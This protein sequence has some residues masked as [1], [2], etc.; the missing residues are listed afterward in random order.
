M[1]L[2]PVLFFILMVSVSF[3]YDFAA[4]PGDGS[5]ANPYQI[6]EPNQLMSIGSDPNLLDKHFILVSDIEF[7]PNNNPAHVFDR[8]LIAPDIEP[9]TFG[10]Q[11]TRFAG[12]FNG[13]NYTISNFT[14][15]Q[16]GGTYIGLFGSCGL[17]PDDAGQIRNLTLSNVFVDAGTGSYVGALV[18]YTSGSVLNCRVEGGSVS[19]GD[20]VGGLV[21][22]FYSYTIVNCFTDCTVQGNNSVG[23]ITGSNCDLILQCRALGQVFGNSEVGGLV[24]VNLEEII[25]C[26]A[27]GDVVGGPGGDSIGG[28]VGLMYPDAIIEDSFARGDVTGNSYVGGF[29]GINID[30]SVT[31]CYSTGS[32]SGANQ[33]GGFVGNNIMGGTYTACFWDTESSG[34][35]F[36]VGSGNDTGIYGRTT[37]E[38]K[39]ESTFSSLGWDFTTPV[40]SIV[41]TVEYP[42]VVSQEYVHDYGGGTGI[43]ADPFLIFTPAHMQE[44]GSKEHHWDMYFKLMNNIDL[45]EYDGQ[46]GREQFN[47]IGYYNHS[48][49]FLPFEGVFNG[50]HHTISNFTHIVSDVG[51]VGLFGYVEG[52]NVVI[53]NLGLINPTVHA[54]SWNHQI[55]ALV[56]Q[57][58]EGL[59]ENCYVQNA[60]VSGDLYVGALA[61]RLIGGMIT[62]CQAHGIVTGNEFIGGLLG[63]NKEGNI[64]NCHAN[65][66]VTATYYYS[67]SGGL[68]GENEFGLISGCT[69]AGNVNGTTLVGGFTGSNPIEIGGEQ[70]YGTIS[71]CSSSGN[72]SGTSYVGGLS[73]ANMGEIIRCWTTGSVT[74]DSDLGGLL[75]GSGGVV[76]DCYATGSVNGGTNVGGLIGM[77]YGDINNSFS[78]GA[79]TGTAPI[80]GLVGSQWYGVI[81]ESLWD[82]QTS[83]CSVMCGDIYQ[84]T[85]CDDS[86]GKTTE[87]MK[88]GS[89]FASIG[90][91]FASEQIN[92]LNDIWRMCVDGVNY[93]KMS[94]EY[95]AVGDFDC[96]D[97]VDINDLHALAY[98]W[99]KENNQPGFSYAC[100]SN[101]DSRININ[102]YATLSINWLNP[103][104]P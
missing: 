95:G 70:R 7:D 67:Y 98:S 35:S 29:V 55:G 101:H 30:G 64:I 59:L 57:F 5:P 41:E 31:N 73:G 54:T 102:D 36:A 17:Y 44:I 26:N 88:T 13:N 86:C 79:V 97:G 61:G 34:L 81:S 80:G 91:D 16:I 92:G 76:T 49:D 33:F 15:I 58:R 1:R 25:R 53:N 82:A 27:T 62:E 68:A 99:L 4:N 75:G 23:G 52:S 43:P 77:N 10:F 100:D 6:S 94:W 71:I 103:P 47:M 83:L 63:K 40:W 69:A 18:G 22:S 93:P 72:V 21:G 2:F 96:P 38:M 24:G 104:A 48:E 37:A 51:S 12:Y 50:N 9:A 85:G 8:A 87:V 84:S 42:I 19:G 28:L 90:W 45:S 39:M 60:D 78:S 3:A 11:G 56:G 46:E 65:V 89:T 66:T 14:C 74:G 20:E 32:A